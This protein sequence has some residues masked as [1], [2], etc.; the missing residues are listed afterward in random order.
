MYR[1][2]DILNSEWTLLSRQED[3]GKYAENYTFKDWEGEGYYLWVV[4]SKRVGDRVEHKHIFLDER[5]GMRE[6]EW[7][8]KSYRHVVAT[9]IDKLVER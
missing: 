4:Y 2:E 1:K 3:A 8:I 5:Y 7:A 6:I 9:L